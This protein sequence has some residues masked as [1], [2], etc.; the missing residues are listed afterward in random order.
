MMNSLWGQWQINNYKCLSTEANAGNMN[1]TII[2]LQIHTG[3]KTDGESSRQKKE[4]KEG[5]R[6]RKGR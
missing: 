5:H 4:K 2:H 6:E 1:L 3:I